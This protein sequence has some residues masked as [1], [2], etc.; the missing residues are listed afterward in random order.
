MASA[1]DVVWCVTDDD[2]LVRL[3]IEIEMTVDSLGR[4]GWEVAAIVRLITEGARQVEK[5]RET[6]QFHFQISGRLDV[7]R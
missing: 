5:F 7:A 3:K 6:N 1:G 4:E 2:E